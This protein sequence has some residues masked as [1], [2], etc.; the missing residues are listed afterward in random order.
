MLNQRF[1]S[2][3]VLISILVAILMVSHTPMGW[4]VPLVLALLSVQG[5]R[6]FVEM[7]ERKGLTIQ[8][9]TLFTGTL[10]YFFGLY[11]LRASK[12]FSPSLLDSAFIFILLF[13]F[14][15]VEGIKKQYGE[16][17][18]STFKSFITSFAAFIYVPWCLGFTMKILYFFEN[19]SVFKNTLGLQFVIFLFLVSKGTDI[20]AYWIGKNYGKHKLADKI[21][22]QKTMEGCL[23]GLVGATLLALISQQVYLT[24]LSILQALIFGFAVSFVSQVGDL[25]ESLLKRDTSCKDSGSLIYGFGGILD[26]LDSILFAAPFLYFLMCFFF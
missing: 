21:S 14:F 22:P 12:V 3:I 18:L 4:L 11:A 6:E 17:N 10:I 24:E 8:K 25:A 16:N 13:F 9:E 1:L 7:A 15:V 23:G 5:I 19:S 2:S 20:F 26:L